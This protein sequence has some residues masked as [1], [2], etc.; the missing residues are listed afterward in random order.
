MKGMQFFSDSCPLLP[1]AWRP[2]HPLA[3]VVTTSCSSGFLGNS[4]STLVGVVTWNFLFFNRKKSGNAALHSQNLLAIFDSYTQLKSVLYYSLVS[5]S[6]T[7][8]SPFTCW[9]NKPRHRT[10]A[11]DRHCTA[12]NYVWKT[13]C[14]RPPRDESKKVAMMFNSFFQQ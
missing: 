5:S 13:F 11:T 9:H 6:R 1:S 14:G 12:R 10:N 2:S 3:L 7:P 8:C 4:F